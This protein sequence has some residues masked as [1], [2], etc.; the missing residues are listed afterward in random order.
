MRILVTRCCS[1]V[2]G[3]LFYKKEK[4]KKEDIK[5]QINVG[6]NSLTSPPNLLIGTDQGKS[7]CKI[8]APL[9]I[10]LSN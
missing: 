1:V 7:D 4:R 8:A 5:K 6:D 10:Y 9:S 3:T 2:A